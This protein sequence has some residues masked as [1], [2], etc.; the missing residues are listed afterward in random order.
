MDRLS[1]LRGLGYFFIT[2]VTMKKLVE[3]HLEQIKE[4]KSKGLV[5]RDEA[6]AIKILNR[7]NYYNLIDGYKWLFLQNNKTGDFVT[8]AD[9]DELHNLYRFDRQLRNA[10]LSYFLQFETTVKSRLA[11]HFSAVNLE[12]NFY[13]KSEN[14]NVNYQK[15]KSLTKLLRKLEKLLNVQE[16]D[17]KQFMFYSDNYNYIPLGVFVKT[18]TFGQTKLMYKYSIPTLKNQIAHNFAGDYEF[19]NGER[20]FFSSEMLESILHGINFFRNACAHEEKLYD[21][22]L[23][24]EPKTASISKALRIPNDLINKGNLFTAIVFLKLGLPRQDYLKLK[25]IL[26]A[27]FDSYYKDFHS[28]PFE[29]VMQIMGFPVNW[30]EI[31]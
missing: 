1:T 8:N 22:R 31:I 24:R 9:F 14:Y 17:S 23:F 25:N 27:L 11:Y 19:E 6:Y 26:F 16:I 20:L 13:L 15:T 28:V 29:Q 2:G 21:Y 7:E 4:L 12:E 10:L 3:N 18:M 5:I 30:Y